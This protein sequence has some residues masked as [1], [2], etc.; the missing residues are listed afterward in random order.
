MKFSPGRFVAIALVAMSAQTEI[1]AQAIY[2]DL[3][4]VTTIAGTHGRSGLADGIG[5]GLPLFLYPQGVALDSLGNLYVVDTENE[6]VRKRT[7]DG[8]MSILAGAEGI[9][10]DTDGTG[11]AARFRV[12]HQVAVDGAGNL[13]VADYGNH[14]IRKI[15]SS[16]IVTTLAGLPGMFGS[17]DGSGS[18]AR[19]FGPSGITISGDQV[20]YVADDGNDTIRKVTLEGTVTTLAG[21][22]RVQGGADGTGSSARFY[23]P[24]ALTCDQM[25]NLYVGDSYNYTIRKVT[26]EGVVTTVA[27]LAG[28]QGSADGIGSAA[29]FFLPTGVAVDAA[30]NIYVCDSGNET[31]RK[32]TAGGTV[33]TFAGAA[34]I[35]NYVDAIGSAARFYS[36]RDVV[37]DAQGN[38]IVVDSGNYTIRKIAP[39]AQVTRVVGSPGV[40]FNPAGIATDSAGNV[41]I[42]DT[43]NYTVRRMTPAGVV[44]V[45]AGLARYSGS[46]DGTG[47][48][49]RFQ[50]VAGLVVD[51]G[52]NIFAADRLNHT[53][54]KITPAG[55]VTTFAGLAGQQGSTNGTGSAAR[56]AYPHSLAIDSANNIYVIDYNYAVRKITPQAVVT[57]FA[58]A[59]DVSGFVDGVGSAARFQ[60]PGG[61]TVD[62]SGNIYLTD[63]QTLRKITP[64]AVVTTLLG[65]PGYSDHIDGT[66][67]V[68]R[69]AGPGSLCIDSGNNIYLTDLGT[70]RRITP[71]LVVRTLAGLP[72][73]GNGHVADGIGSAARF[74]SPSGIA[75]DNAGRLY[76]SDYSDQTIRVAVPALALANAVSR[77]V[78]GGAGAFDIALPVTGEPAVECRSGGAKGDYEIVVTFNNLMSSAR[79]IL[80]SGIGSI[81]GAPAINERSVTINLTGVADAQNVSIVL[82]K[83][84]DNFGQTYPDQTVS[85]NILVG[86]VNGNKTVNSSDVSQ[87]KMQSGLAITNANFRSDLDA[88]GNINATDTSLA[89]ANSGHGLH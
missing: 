20:L 31:I 72:G 47:S 3:Y 7:P 36:P 17:N 28:A 26:T 78:H 73:S 52:G 68:V 44:S 43:Y 33:S 13:Y 23:G 70:I 12:P 63:Y 38:L 50:D 34:G 16:G 76:V 9:P 82:R 59:S 53:I 15:T 89:K 84:T 79:A 75:I 11:S 48:S 22:P 35:A 8:T 69:F 86:D 40:L 5:P 46:V 74:N 25:G 2:D 10:G 80:S 19:F 29:R 37:I 54:R 60:G 6:V 57:T 66:G 56:F 49:A 87:V 71:N 32:I 21:S 83:A 14:T 41:Y 61:I 77:K 18:S 1:H 64:N 58:G 67:N 81:E 85:M 55:V 4:A 30:G 62:S 24:T 51:S 42:G 45:L 88:N 39:N 65:S 27:G